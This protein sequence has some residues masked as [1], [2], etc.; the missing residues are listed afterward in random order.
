MLVQSVGS[1]TRKETCK[2]C[3]CW[4]QYTYGSGIKNQFQNSYPGVLSQ[5]LGEGYDVRN[6]GISARV[7]LNKGDHPYMHEQKFRDLLAFQP[8]IV[9]IKLGTNDSNPGI[10]V[11]E[12]ILRRI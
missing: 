10:G 12:K 9:T 1:G 5:L 8:D 3:L 2:D 7:L 4:K 6:F 11:M